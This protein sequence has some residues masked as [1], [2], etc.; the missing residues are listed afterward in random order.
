M[1]NEQIEKFIELALA[2]G[3]LTEKEKQVLFKKAE[4]AGIDL[5]EFELVLDAK[6]FERNQAKTVIPPV[7]A[8]KSDKFGDVK[9]CPACGAVVESFQTTCGECGYEFRNIEANKTI[10]RLSETL[11]RENNKKKKVEIIRNFPIPH[12]NEDLLELLYFI[13]PKTEPANKDSNIF[14]WRQKFKELLL[15]SKNAFSGNTKVLADISEIENRFNR[16]SSS[17]L[18]WCRFSLFSTGKKIGLGCGTIMLIFFVA[19]ITIAIIADKKEDVKKQKVQKDIQIEE[20]TL[21][22]KLD[23]LEALLKTKDYATLKNELKKLRWRPID[24]VTYK[25]DDKDNP[26]DQIKDFWNDNEKKSFDAYL[27]RKKELN[28]MLPTNYRIDKDDIQQ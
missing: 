13:V 21:V 20:K 9:K 17:S 24:D 22:S 10:Q 16:T 19:G 27:Q 1:Y 7:S 18:L 2:D 26:T 15:R 23:S 11:N 6:L 12:T 4:A 25:Y 5:D 28:N 3:V 8:P 14:V